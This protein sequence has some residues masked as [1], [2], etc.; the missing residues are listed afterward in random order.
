MV[1]GW[2]LGGIWVV[3]EWLLDAGLCLLAS[4]WMAVRWSVVRG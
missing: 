3:F 2:Y 4:G 1:F